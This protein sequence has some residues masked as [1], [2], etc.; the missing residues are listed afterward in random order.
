MGPY[1][2]IVVAANLVTVV[3]GAAVFRCAYRAHVRTESSSLRALAIGLGFVTLGAGA[4]LVVYVHP[5]AD[6]T[7]AIAAQSVL[8]AA[9]VVVLAGSLKRRTA[10][11]QLNARR[12][13]K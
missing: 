8:L 4:G 11:E 9:G 12:S 10:G 6:P 2:L 7:H 1:T 13:T 3:F 5:V